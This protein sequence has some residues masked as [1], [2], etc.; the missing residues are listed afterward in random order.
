MQATCQSLPDRA[1]ASPRP[2]LRLVQCVEAARTA[3]TATLAQIFL[4]TLRM[5]ERSEP[6]S[7]DVRARLQGCQKAH[8]DNVGHSPDNSVHASCG[9]AALA[10]RRTAMSDGFR[11]AA[12]QACGPANKKR[13]SH[14]LSMLG[15]SR[16]GA[17]AVW[18][19]DTLCIPCAPPRSRPCWRRAVAA[20]RWR[21][22]CSPRANYAGSSTQRGLLPATAA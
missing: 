9:T 21:M 17:H 11:E 19:G 22:S 8:T 13:L 14:Y 4:P 15:I 18:L 2:F 6:D 12:C 7:P 3:R 16:K 10:T 20:W 1:S 5:T